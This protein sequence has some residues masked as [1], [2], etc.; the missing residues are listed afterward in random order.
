MLARHNINLASLNLDNPGET[1]SDFDSNYS[2]EVLRIA[3]SS[4]N[5]EQSPIAAVGD[6]PAAFE[7]PP[8]QYRMQLIE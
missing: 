1:N 3:D 6:R 8:P 7:A 4:T 2:S 5:Q